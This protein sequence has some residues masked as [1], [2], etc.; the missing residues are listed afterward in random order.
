MDFRRLKVAG[1]VEFRFPS[2]PD[3]RGSFTSALMESH[4][5]EAV[6]RRPFPIGQVSYTRSRR[7]V[8]RGIHYTAT[9]PGC[10]KFVHCPAGRALDMVVDLRVGSPTWGVWDTVEFD[11]ESPKAVYIPVG[12]GHAVMAL[13][14]DTIIAYLLSTEYV[15]ENELSVSVFSPG[16]D[17][18]IPA[19]PAPLRSVRDREAPSVDQALADGT[20]PEFTRC[21]ALEEAS[22]GP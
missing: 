8:V 6:G 2:F 3:E 7:G 15:A 9:P 16:I 4:F 1:A 20:L 22:A 17:L 10:A 5:I 13:E 14:D 11:P 21:A 18:P 12:V 19:E